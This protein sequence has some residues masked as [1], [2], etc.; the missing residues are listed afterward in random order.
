M[1]LYE[2][3]AKRITGSVRENVSLAPFTTFRIGGTADIFV[4]PASAEDVIEI[5]KFVVEYN[6]SFFILGNGSNVL[7]SDDGIRGVT[8]NLEA[9][10]DAL[11]CSANIVT[12][13]AGVRM[14][15]FVDF[16]IRHSLQGVEMLAGIPATIGG[17]VWMNA[18]CYGG[19]TSDH[20]LDVTLARDDSIVTLT[21]AECGFRYRHSGF[22]AGDIVLGTRFELPA[23]DLTHLQEI[24]RKHL[25][26][27]NDVQPVNLPNCGSVFKNPKPE[28]S[29]ALI[30]RAGLKGTRIGGAEISPKHANFITN[31][32]NAS[33]HDVIA[34]MN[35]ARQKVFEMSGIVLEP[36]VQL[37]G[38]GQAPLDYL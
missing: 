36:E 11:S 37:I 13:Q 10:F 26:H 21:K 6:L 25:L 4:E 33:A 34:L 30:E 28:F 24:K 29:A 15:A 5:K 38:F 8:M 35:L 12:A 16:V 3:L 1:S 18:G 23:G 2:Q 9:G 27:R 32:D 19:E 20:I 31:I 14:A 17:A 22:R 7:V